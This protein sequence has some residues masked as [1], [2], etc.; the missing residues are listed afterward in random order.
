MYSPTTDNLTSEN[1][2][3]SDL[4]H[5][6]QDTSKMIKKKNQL[7]CVDLFAGAGGFS[8]AA[9]KA[10]LRVVAAVEMDEHACSTYTA[11]LVANK[12]LATRPK[13]YFEDILTLEPDALK[14]AHFIDGTPCDLV[15]GGPP[16]Q[17]FSA[18]RINGAGVGDPRNKLVLRYFEFV[19]CLQPK[20]F[21]MENVPGL[22]WPRHRE[23]LAE[24]L[25][26]SE[27]ADYRIIGPI[28]LDARDY[29][30]PQRRKR[31]FVLGI[32]K[33]TKFDDSVWPPLATHGDNDARKINRSLKRWVAAKA[34]F[35]KPLRD[36]DENNIHM[37]HS[38]ELIS[39]FKATP[40][41]GGSRS[42]SGR[43]LECHKNYDGH[44][45]VYGRIDPTMPGPT[46]TTAC[47][48]PS[49]G[50]FVHPTEHHGI[51]A[52]H[53]ARFQTFPEGFVFKGGITAAGKQI[54]N[55]VPVK[56]GEILLR[57][58]AEGLRLGATKRAL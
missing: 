47:I 55:A 18:H 51:T 21:L 9:Q 54:G 57:T 4:A 31:V 23:F 35:K 42:E 3:E 50:R 17:G 1:T 52:R 40:Q 25:A 13:L 39:V 26:E 8:L 27:S 14:K 2:V 11:N 20:V 48:N 19:R 6:S 5:A 28:A 44:N 30:V 32:H 15:L 56:L 10:N 33:S 49:K 46:M 24:F 45:D 34:V 58:I 43:I 38:N 37:N 22:L 7:N 16:C 53:A 41:N 36:S 12:K 29:G